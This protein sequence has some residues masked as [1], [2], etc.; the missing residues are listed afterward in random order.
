L[1]LIVLINLFSPT[2]PSFFL[3]FAITWSIAQSEYLSS[4]SFG[5]NTSATSF[6]TTTSPCFCHS[7]FNTSYS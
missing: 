6:R 1:P 4:V 5:H 7:N 3:I 2:S